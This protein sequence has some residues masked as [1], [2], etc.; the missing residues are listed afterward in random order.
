MSTSASTTSPIPVYTGTAMTG[1]DPRTH[2]WYH[3][4]DGRTRRICDDS[5]WPPGVLPRRSKFAVYLPCDPCKTIYFDDGAHGQ[6]RFVAEPYAV[7]LELDMLNSLST[8]E[9]LPNKKERVIDIHPIPLSTFARFYEATTESAKL[10]IVR[11]A[12]GSGYD[13]YWALRNTLAETHFRSDDL[14]TFEDAVIGLVGSLKSESQRTHY[15]KICQGYI[16]FWKRFDEAHVFPVS[17]IDTEIE[18]LTIKVN[19]EIGMRDGEDE[20]PIKLHLRAKAPTRDY[21]RAI[22]GVTSKASEFVWDTN[23]Q[24]RILD[25]RKGELA[26]YVPFPQDFDMIME[27]AASHFVDMWERE[28]RRVREGLLP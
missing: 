6:G 14:S 1:P 12:R 24:P 8:G 15:R 10:R 13:F 7:P 3:A 17:P 27:S 21:R 18:G 20:R 2:L 22:Q 16:N 19:Y 25:T 28:D 4:P 23:W 5:Q 11:E 9:S 26:E